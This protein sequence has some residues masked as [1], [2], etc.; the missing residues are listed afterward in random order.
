MNQVKEELTVQLQQKVGLRAPAQHQEQAVERKTSEKGLDQGLGPILDH[1]DR[2]QN[3]LIK[4]NEVDLLHHWFEE[5][6]EHHKNKNNL[7]VGQLAL[8]M[9]LKG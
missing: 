4:V 5:E 8:M 9:Q 1:Q 2:G 3:L 7:E 6:D